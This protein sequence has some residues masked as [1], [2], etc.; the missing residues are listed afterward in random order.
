VGLQSISL[1]LWRRLQE[2]PLDAIE[3]FIVLGLLWCAAF[4]TCIAPYADDATSVRQRLKSPSTQSSVA[5]DNLG[6]GVF[7]HI[8]YGAR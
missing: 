3:H 1:G 6:R 8:I 7:S 5:S 4:V 2:S